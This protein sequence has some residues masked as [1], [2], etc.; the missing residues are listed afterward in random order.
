MQDRTSV[1]AVAANSMPL[2]Y[3]IVATIVTGYTAL[4]IGLHLNTDAY[5][6]L[7]IPILLIFQLVIQR[8]P[9]R[10]LW[11]RGGP[12]IIVDAG[13]VILWI[14][15]AIVPAYSAAT[16]AE[17]G[18]LAHAALSVAAVVGAFGAAYAIR[19]AGPQ[20]GAQL[21]FCSLTVGAIAA[22]PSLLS[23]VAPNLLHLHISGR[24]PSSEPAAVWPIVQAAGSVFLF[25]PVGF[26]VEEVF[27]RGA[28]DTYLHRGE[29]GTGWVSA[30]FVSAL[31]GLWHLPG[32]VESGLDS[33]HLVSVVVSLLAAQI[34]IGV[35]LSLWWRKS[36]N[37][38]VPD[39]AHAFLEAIRTVPILTA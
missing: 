35:P 30:V 5:L 34:V 32:Q 12:P 16:A 15:L 24:A 31:W 23:A 8:Q 25:A 13:L 18:N 17:S 38:I 22:V 11:V 36:C 27:F 6:L 1:G 4:G 20:T 10:T 28:L 9:I 7:G 39:T 3:L 14:A 37:L 21:V 33:S 2:R 19:S 26:V 29:E